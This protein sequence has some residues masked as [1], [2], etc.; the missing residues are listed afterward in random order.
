MRR[1]ERGRGACRAQTA[2]GGRG[3][4][5]R[6]AGVTYIGVLL[7]VAALG[8]AA[9]QAVEVLSTQQQRDRET[10][11]LFVGD[12]FRRAIVSYYHSGEGGQYPSS[13]QDLVEDNRAMHPIRHLRRVY[14]DPLTD[15]PDWGVVHGPGGTIMGVYSQAPGHPI[16]QAN[17]PAGD[18]GFSDKKSYRDWVFLDNS[19][20]AQGQDPAEQKTDLRR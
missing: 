1:G 7:L 13:L 5:D 20:K 10:Q 2:A 9:T 4:T 16:K 6:Q 15:T 8:M 19:Q 11:L 12:Q 18:E 17:F 14:V 3:V